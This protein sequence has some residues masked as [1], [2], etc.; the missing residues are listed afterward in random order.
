MLQ[1][2][3]QKQPV[4]VVFNSTD[5]IYSKSDEKKPPYMEDFSR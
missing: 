1:I 3:Q 5:L 4:G 2:M